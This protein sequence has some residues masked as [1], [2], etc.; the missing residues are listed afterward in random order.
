MKFHCWNAARLNVGD[1]SG[2]GVRF[3]LGVVTWLTPFEN[4]MPCQDRC[5]ERRSEGEIGMILPLR[6][7]KLFPIPA[8]KDRIFQSSHFLNFISHVF[9]LCVCPDISL[10]F[11]AEQGAVCLLKL[12][13]VELLPTA[14]T[15]V[16]MVASCLVPATE[17][18]QE[19]P[20][21]V[22]Y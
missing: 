12:Q 2:G 13:G 17:S 19:V 14:K 11:V 4:V 3:V 7:E 10:V 1:R 8:L 9:F 18:V 20:G 6:P 15:V 5:R 16:L 21:T 22:T